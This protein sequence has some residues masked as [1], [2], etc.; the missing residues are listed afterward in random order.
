[1]N[2]LTVQ[3]KAPNCQTLKNVYTQFSWRARAFQNIP[4]KDSPSPVSH[5]D[6]ADGG[7]EGGHHDVRDG[8]VQ[9]EVVGHA[10]H[11]TVG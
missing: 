5:V 3:Y 8:Q 6:E 1:M 11:P 4:I 10:P 9:Q 2:W 7:V